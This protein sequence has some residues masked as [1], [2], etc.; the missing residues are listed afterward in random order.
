METLPG[1]DPEPKCKHYLVYI[2]R[3]VSL[4]LYPYVSLS[5]DLKIVGT[6]R[7]PSA[8]HFWV[9]GTRRVPTTLHTY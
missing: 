7:V 8:L 9:Y 5:V 2:V 6:L 3:R 4:V 1:Q